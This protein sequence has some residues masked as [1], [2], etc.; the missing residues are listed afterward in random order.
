MSNRRPALPPHIGLLLRGVRHAAYPEPGFFKLRLRRH[1]PWVPALIWRPCPLILPDPAIA[2]EDWCMPT[3]R[4]RPLRSRIG[5]AEA[6][7]LE[8]WERGRKIPAHE[9][10]WRLELRDWAVQHDPRQPEA[11]PQE[12][13]NLGQ[14][15]SLF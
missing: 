6:D 7:P 5:D 15:P 1:G 12:P 3:E 14:L 2:P 10:I 9:Y 13:A 8:V 4:S 11:R